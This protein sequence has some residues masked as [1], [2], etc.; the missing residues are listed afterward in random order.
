MRLR[1]TVEDLP[2]VRSRNRQRRRVFTAE[3]VSDRAVD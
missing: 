2:E 3:D 1:G